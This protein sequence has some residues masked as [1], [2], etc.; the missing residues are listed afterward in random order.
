[1][2]VIPT[3][4][5]NQMEVTTPEDVVA[6]LLRFMIMNPGW[7]SSQIEASLLSMRK[8][9]ARHTE[10]IEVLPGAVQ[11]VLDAAIKRHYPDLSASVTSTR[12][13]E[14]NN[15]NLHIS[16]TDSYGTPVLSTDDFMIEDG[17][18]VLN[19]EVRDVLEVDR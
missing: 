19:P 12:L 18:F 5:I 8:F 14:A 10:N 11:N 1:M 17:Q 6:Y 15:Y 7:T 13:D 9:V 2:T 3:L 16:V 4:F